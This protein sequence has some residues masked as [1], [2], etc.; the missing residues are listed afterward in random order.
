MYLHTS[1]PLDTHHTATQCSY[2]HTPPIYWL[3]AGP[4][5][6]EATL[7]TSRPSL[8]DLVSHVVP[9][10]TPKWYEVGL[11]LDLEPY[12]LDGIEKLQDQP[13]KMFAEWLKGSSCTWEKVFDA[14]EK[15]CG[16][17]PM[18][19]I[20]AAVVESIRG[21]QSTGQHLAHHV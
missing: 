17:A 15:T 9:R 13:R 14:V 16:K 10:I 12:V 4:S 8:K 5:S 3:H 20:Q 11:Q 6:P 21:A 1:P 2:I 19:E 7:S 18:E